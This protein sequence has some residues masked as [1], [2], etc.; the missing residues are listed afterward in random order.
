TGGLLV[1][2]VTAVEPFREH[3][4]SKHLVLTKNKEGIRDGKAS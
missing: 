1:P 4:L 2:V 3:K